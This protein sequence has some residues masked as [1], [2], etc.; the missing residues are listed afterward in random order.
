VSCSCS[1]DTC[2]DD[3]ACS[4][5]ETC[6]CHGTTYN[7]GGNT[8][9]TGN[10]RVDSDCGVGGYC[11]PSASTTGCGGGIAGYYCHTV[12]D[13]CINDSDCTGGAG[14]VCAYSAVDLAWTCQ[15][16]LLCP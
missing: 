16:E 9:V 3:A 2:A 11:S 12:E 6:A 10:C 8:C 14:E 5:N 4:P 15:Q 7:D 1:Y 13:Q